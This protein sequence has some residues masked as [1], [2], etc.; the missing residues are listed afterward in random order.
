MAR[1]IGREIASP[2]EARRIIGIRKEA[3]VTPG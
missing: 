2:E 1:D 3:A